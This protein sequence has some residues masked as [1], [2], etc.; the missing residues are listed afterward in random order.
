MSEP[1][2]I[3]TLEELGTAALDRKAVVIPSHPAFTKPR[4]AAFIVSMQA[5]QVLG[6]LHQG[7]FIYTPKNKRL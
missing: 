4:A 3:T 7:L 1:K 5:R 6:L 2:R